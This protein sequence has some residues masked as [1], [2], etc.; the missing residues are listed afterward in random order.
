MRIV[1][2]FF[3]DRMPAEKRGV[4][5]CGLSRPFRTRWGCRRLVCRGLGGGS[6]RRGSCPAAL[7]PAPRSVTWFFPSAR[8]RQYGRR[9][10]GRDGESL[11]EASGVRV[12]VT[13]RA[14]REGCAAC[15]SKST[16]SSMSSGRERRCVWR[17]GALRRATGLTR[18]S[19]AGSPAAGSAPCCGAGTGWSRK[20]TCLKGHAHLTGCRNQFTNKRRARC[21]TLLWIFI[22]QAV[23]HLGKGSGNRIGKRGNGSLTWAKAISTWDF[24]VKGRTP[25]A[26][27]Y[28]ITPRA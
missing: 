21:G 5:S 22:Q 6:V 1:P 10:E 16:G 18:V 3:R 24:P 4:D 11:C 25:A 26:A 2:F 19:T 9:G 15:A 23:D 13:E 14:A 17:I 7:C 20:W 12:C 8:P 28:A 27:S